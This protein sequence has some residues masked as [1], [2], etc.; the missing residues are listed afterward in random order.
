MVI[1]TRLAR[2]RHAVTQHT[3]IQRASNRPPDS[4]ASLPPIDVILRGDWHETDHGPIFIRDEWFPLDHRHGSSPLR[5]ALDAPPEALAHLLG[6]ADAPRASSMAFFDIETTGLSGGTGTWVILA[7]LGSYEDG[8]FRMRQYFLADIAHERAMLSMLAAD[9]ERFEGLVTYNGRSFDMPFVQ[10]RMTLAR[11]RYPCER[12]A[13]LDLLHAVR[14]LYRHRM[15]NCR[16]SEAERH[17]LRIDRQDDVPGSLIPPLYFDYVRAGRAAPLRAVFR[18][19][20][21]D[22]LSLVGVLAGCARLL[23]AAELNPD[24]AIA[25]ARWW[26][27]A[28]RPERAIALYRAALPWL[29]GGDDWSW[30]AARHARLCKRAGLRHEAAPLW[31]QLWQR[32]DRMAGLELAKHREHRQRDAASAREVVLRLLD[33]AE[34]REEESLH[35][36]LRRLERKLAR[37]AGAGGRV[38]SWPGGGI[39]RRSLE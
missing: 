8:A 22:V 5:A 14:R 37:S 26:E 29:E 3:A 11:V 2:L 4:I 15:P 7:G 25:A 36:R 34:G 30:A 38:A 24:D 19:N 33:A 21:D 1:D 39:G 16:L 31:E 20:T 10:T 12:H 13:H 27:Y 6:A 18:H 35:N 32:G 23:S 9:L 28:R 17:L